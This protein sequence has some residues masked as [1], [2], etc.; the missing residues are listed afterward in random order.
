M[1]ALTRDDVWLFGGWIEFAQHWDGSS[2]T[3]TPGPATGTDSQEFIRDFAVAPGSTVLWA[4][5]ERFTGGGLRTPGRTGTVEE[6]TAIVEKPNDT[7]F[8]AYRRLTGSA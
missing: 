7:A 2:W 5:G 4:V 6:L 3:V 8:A 1:V